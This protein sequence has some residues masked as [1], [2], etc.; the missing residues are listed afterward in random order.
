LHPALTTI[1]E[2]PEQIGKQMVEVL[3]NRIAKPGQ[4]PQRITVPTELMKRDSCR[5]IS[6]SQAG[7]REEAARLATVSVRSPDRLR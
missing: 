3:L 4:K 1:R 5:Q 7:T 6:N 2:F